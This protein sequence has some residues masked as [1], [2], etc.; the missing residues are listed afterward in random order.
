MSSIPAHRS[1]IQ[2]LLRLK[3]ERQNWDDFL[4]SAFEDRLPPETVRE[5]ERRESHEGRRTFA[6]VEGAHPKQA[7]RRG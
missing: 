4:I 1:T 5:L 7:R 6:E 2:L 3:P